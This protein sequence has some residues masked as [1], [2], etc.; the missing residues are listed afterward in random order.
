MVRT[1]GGDVFLQALATAHQAY[2]EA[3]GLT[4]DRAAPAVPARLKEP[5]LAFQAALRG[6]VV[7]IAGQVDE[8]DP[9]TVALAR[10]LL[11]PLSA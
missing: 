11:A 10:K 4:A 6:D 3:L 8:D 7:R 1:L 2:G 9:Q 5:L